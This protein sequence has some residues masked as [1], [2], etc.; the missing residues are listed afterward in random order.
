MCGRASVSGGLKMARTRIL[1]VEDERAQRD[2]LKTYLAR[3]AYE[4]DSVSTGEEALK[5]LLSRSY[6]VML[7]DLRLPEMDGLTLLRRAREIDDRLMVLLM[8]AYASVESAVE[9]LRLGAH[10]YLLKPLYLEEVT[11]KVARLVE[12]RTLLQE[13]TRLRSLLRSE[14]SHED[15]V[16]TSLAMQDVMRW[17]QRAA[18]TT[19]TVLITGETGTGKELMSRAIHRASARSGEPFVAVNLAAVPSDM[20]ESEIFGHERGAFT[21]ASRS[22]EGILRSA[23]GGT[24]LLDEIGELCPDVQAKILRALE[25]KEVRAVGSD[26]T[27]PFR[28]RIIAATHQDLE[29][30]VEAGTFRRDLYYR[31]NVLRIGI[32]P[33]RDR[34][35]DV[36]PLVQKLLARICLDRDLHMPAV[37][38]VAM[39]ALVSHPWKGNVRELVNVLERALVLS[40]G[41][42]IEMD[43]LPPEVGA[44]KEQLLALSD[45]VNRFER[46]HIAMVL[47]LCEGNRERAA[48]ELG[49]SPATL[50]R[51]LDRLDLNKGAERGDYSSP[52]QPG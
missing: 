5:L 15:V 52:K 41:S 18:A 19:A 43:A 33:L 21:G 51:R 22:R 50:Y 38:A 47:H 3:A 4:V 16:A 39:R 46:T 49:I 17:V 34:P 42:D 11:R 45:A 30:M 32:P 1:V 2:A 13:N 31:L 37:D 26:A 40:D 24:V 8:T 35:E 12:H 23:R 48:R 9:A 6:A 7:T 44:G 36:P 28:A 20:V 10:D 14:G 27:S 25:E 29:A